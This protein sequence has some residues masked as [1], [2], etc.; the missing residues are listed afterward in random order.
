MTV[1]EKARVESINPT[2][3]STEE[4]NALAILE[5]LPVAEV[6]QLKNLMELTVSDVIGPT[7]LSEFL[8][9]AQKHNLDLSEAG[10]NAFKDQHRLGN[11]GAVQGVI[12]AQTAQVYYEQLTEKATPTIPS[13]GG[14]R[15]INQAG[16]H[17]IEEF[18]GLSKKLADGRIAAYLDCV[19]VPTIGYG[20]TKN[21]HPGMIITRQQAEEFLNQDLRVAEA[22]VE[23]LVKVSLNDN[24]F[25]ALISFA[26]N[27]GTGALAHSTLLCDLNAENYQA[28][29]D[30]F[31][32][33]NRAGGRVLSGLTRRREAERKLFLS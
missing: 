17:L 26:F 29:A 11:T 33:W 10:V 30:Q 5:S 21:V 2:N 7:T 24:Q 20:H 8:K 22:G 12:G 14:V 3:L 6:D 25:A 16:L 18:E 15:Q 4:H 23:H 32:R 1:M 31:L 28:A 27:L 13:S 9:F 19:G